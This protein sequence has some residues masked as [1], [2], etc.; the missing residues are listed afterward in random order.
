MLAAPATT[1][2]HDASTLEWE[3]AETDAR[4][5]HGLSDP[6]RLAIL[7]LLLGGEKNVSELV[8]AL[9]VPQSRVSSHL[10]CLR[11]CGYVA[12]R[13]EGKYLYYRV[14]DP[15]IHALLLLGRTIARDHAAQLASCPTLSEDP[16]D[17][18]SS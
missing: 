1:R 17:E 10:A 13:R 15:R 14:A 7:E 5:F 16:E 11:H 2:K 8:A 18:L 4:F 12:H 6:T 9:G 3:T